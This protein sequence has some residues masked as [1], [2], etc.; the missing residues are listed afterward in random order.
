MPGVIARE[1][2]LE[3]LMGAIRECEDLV[4]PHLTLVRG[5]SGQ[6]KSTL[7]EEHLDCVYED[8]PDAVVLRGSCPDESGLSR[9]L[10]P[11]S[12]ALVDLLVTGGDDDESKSRR[13][14]ARTAVEEFGPELLSLLFPPA[15]LIGK[16][17][18]ALSRDKQLKKAIDEANRRSSADSNEQQLRS[19]FTAVVSSL[20]ADNLVVL[21]S[22]LR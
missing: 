7:L 17:A 11:I 21:V 16:V 22:T 5:G 12:D 1:N 2:E 9:A 15:A 14:I 4:A 10:L 8:H 6:G 19:Q 18:T 3:L 13:A 20:A